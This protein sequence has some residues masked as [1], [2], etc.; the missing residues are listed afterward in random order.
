MSAASARISREALQ[1]A[2]VAAR[3]ID[4]KISA[5]LCWVVYPPQYLG[6]MPDYESDIREH[7]I[8]LTAQ[9]EAAVR[10]AR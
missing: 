9:I 4:L 7:L 2:A 3:L 1:Q 5:W 10:P 6:E 8:E